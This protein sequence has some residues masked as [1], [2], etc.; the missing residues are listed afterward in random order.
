[1]SSGTMPPS[2][3]GGKRFIHDP[4]IEGQPETKASIKLMFSSVDQ[5]EI[6]AMRT[7]RVTQRVGNRLEFRKLDQI[8]KYYDENG[9]EHSVSNSCIDMDAQMAKLF[10]VSKAVLQNVIFCHQEET[11]W[12][13]ADQAHLKKIF[14]EIFDTEKYTKILMEL[15]TEAKNYKA[16]KKLLNTEFE[17]RGKDYQIY[18]GIIKSVEENKEKLSNFEKLAIEINTELELKN[19]ALKQFE[20]KEK[21]LV[22][23]DKEI[24]ALQCSAKDLRAQFQKISTNPL[25]KDFGKK[26]EELEKMLSEIDNA[27]EEI[28][29]EKSKIEQEMKDLKISLSGIE[30]E[31]ITLKINHKR[32]EEILQEENKLNENFNEIIK[33]AQIIPLINDYVN[34]GKNIDGIKSLAEIIKF[35]S[36]FCA[37]KKTDILKEENQFLEAKNQTTIS[38]KLRKEEQKQIKSLLDEKLKEI[39]QISPQENTSPK[40]EAKYI[41]IAEKLAKFGFDKNSYSEYFISKIKEI[42]TLDAQG[43]NAEFSAKISEISAKITENQQKFT[44]ELSEFI[45][46]LCEYAEISKEISTNS[47]GVDLKK[48]NLQENIMQLEYFLGVIYKNRSKLKKINSEIEFNEEIFKSYNSQQV[49]FF[50]IAYKKEKYVNLHAQISIYEQILSQLNSLLLKYNWTQ[51]KKS[52]LANISCESIEKFDNFI[53]TKEDLKENIIKKIDQI[54]EQIRNFDRVLGDRQLLQ[55]QIEMN[56]SKYEIQKNVKLIKTD[57]EQKEQEKSQITKELENKKPLLAEIAQITAKYHELLGEGKNLSKIVHNQE[58]ELQT[59]LYKNI[60]GTIKFLQF[61]ML[62]ADKISEAI[63][64]RHDAI[65]ESVMIYHNKKMEQINKVIKDLW[66]LTYKGTDIDTIEIKSDLDKTGSRFH[67]FNYRIVF[68]NNDGTELDMRGRCSA[69]QKVLGSLLI[70]LALAEAFC[71]DCG[72]LALDE[73]TTNLD[74]ENISGLAEALT[75]I[76]NERAGHKNFQLIVISHDEPFI[77]A[78]GSKFTEH[79]WKVEKNSHGYSTVRK[80]EL[81]EFL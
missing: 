38:L 62:T 68:K 67:S 41:L 30:T 7:Y 20:E 15:R 32:L 43:R 28:L 61:Q 70:R 14:D 18:K 19:S 31:I 66:K 79:I 12:P 10:G 27:K 13:F 3:E 53:K 34:Q 52:E 51:H 6:L 22:E 56:I 80:V 21:K 60:E 46:L 75:D 44:L 45:Q 78:L 2:S 39:S 55:S 11:L 23:L 81:K 65:E 49:F 74:T 9:K 73:P 63:L 47:K 4:K 26:R 71:A 29:K 17:I 76:I 25:Y 50:V 54:T 33:N 1:M 37:S 69:G 58:Q 42:S 64:V 48:I 59:P 40:L 57:Y 5:K 24:H 8:M 72:V 35:I 77:Q 36:E 16:Q